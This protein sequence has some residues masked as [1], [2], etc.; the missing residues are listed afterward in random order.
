MC[1]TCGTKYKYY[2]FSS[3]NKLYG[4]CFGIQMFTL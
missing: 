1:E 2:D 3:I 4:W